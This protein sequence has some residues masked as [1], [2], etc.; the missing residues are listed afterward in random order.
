MNE[1]NFLS[2]LL[3]SDETLRLILALE[4]ICDCQLVK[5]QLSPSR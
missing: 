3:L 5:V 1:K 4:S 2:N